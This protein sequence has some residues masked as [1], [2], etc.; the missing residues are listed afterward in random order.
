MKMRDLLVF[1]NHL[2]GAFFV[3]SNI[4]SNY[5]TIKI[6]FRVY[7]YRYILDKQSKHSGTTQVANVFK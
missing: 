4:K 7:I 2:K 5:K 1:I 3:L 6:L